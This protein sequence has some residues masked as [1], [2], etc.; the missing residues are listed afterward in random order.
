[1]AIDPRIA[2]GV[3]PI[4]QQPNM[5]AQYAQIMGI[6]AAQQELESNEGLRGELSQGI[7]DDPS[8]LLRYGPKGRAV[9]E[10]VLKGK[11]E[12][13]ESDDKRNVMLGGLAGP[14]MENPTLTNFKFALD[15]AESFG[16]MTPQQKQ[17][18]LTQ[19]GSNP[20]S[21][22]AYASQI[23]KGSITAQA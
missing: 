4:Q 8:K 1:M 19:Y 3:Q 22:K 9:Y 5:L 10:S 17:E 6:K 13:L 7:P 18:V 12:K 21:I 15:R 2:L 20:E 14:V 16:L 11:K 23:F